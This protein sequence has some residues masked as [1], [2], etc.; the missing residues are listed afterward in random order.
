MPT[1]KYSV[2]LLD[3]S[4][5]GGLRYVGLTK[6]LSARLA[7]HRQRGGL[8]FA[9]GPPRVS[10]LHEGL[11][12]YE[13]TDV[14]RREISARGTLAPSGYNQSSGGEYSGRRRDAKFGPAHL[15]RLSRAA[16]A[17]LEMA[18]AL[19]ADE[20]VGRVAALVAPARE[21]SVGETPEKLAARG[22]AV[23]LDR[24]GLALAIMVGLRRRGIAVPHIAKRSGLGIGAVRGMLRDAGSA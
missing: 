7:R 18:G 16:L 6:H 15:L 20:A 10:V 11:A 22:K 8:G 3:W 13:A 2:Y 9:L 17:V 24:Y 12:L 23:V 4:H 5:I 21:L 14:E 1:E 19:S